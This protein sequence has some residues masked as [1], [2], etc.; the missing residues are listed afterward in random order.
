MKHPKQQQYKMSTKTKL[1]DKKMFSV[2]APPQYLIPTSTNA[3]ICQ[4]QWLR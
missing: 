2:K 3:Y 4:L 1:I